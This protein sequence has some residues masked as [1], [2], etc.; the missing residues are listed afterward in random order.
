MES[1]F[2]G[3]PIHVTPNRPPSGQQAKKVINYSTP[4][5]SKGED[6]VLKWTEKRNKRSK[7]LPRGSEIDEIMGSSKAKPQGP[8]FFPIPTVGSV[9]GATQA[10]PRRQSRV[11]LYENDRR[12]QKKAQAKFSLKKFFKV[13][14]S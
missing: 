3:Q 1:S 4:P 11:E 9:T 14:K 5:P 2:T 13:R 7:S 8:R 12:Q 6:E 10:S